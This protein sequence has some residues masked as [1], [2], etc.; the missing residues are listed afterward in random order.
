M[1]EVS[2]ALKLVRQT[3]QTLPPLTVPLPEALGCMLA[4]AIASDVDSPPHDKTIVD[5]YAVRAGDCAKFP[6]TLQVIE[7]VSAGKVPTKVLGTSQAARIMTGA[8]IPSGCDAVVMIEETSST[9]QTSITIS[10]PRVRAGQN[11]VRRASSMAQGEQ[12][13]SPGMTLRSIELGLLAEVGRSTVSVIPRP[14]VAILPTGNELVPIT[15]EP[16]PGFIRNSNGPMLAALVKD[17]GCQA[18]ELDVAR[19]ETA[20]LRQR[21][22]EG[23]EADV[24]LLSGGVSMGAYDLVPGTLA[25]LGVQ[26]VFHKLNLKPGKPLW[27]GVREA[28]SV[29]AG[30]ARSRRT[31]VFGLPGNPVSSLVCFALFVRPA[32]AWLAGRNDGELPRRVVSLAHDFHYR[33]GRASYIPASI[34]IANDNKLLASLVPYS[35][36]GDLRALARSQALL[37]F[38]GGE[39]LFPAGTPVEALMLL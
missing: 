25:D 3:S 36:S 21:C 23:L 5:G 18:I 2:D 16:A 7:E 6:V 17:A 33:G 22:D 19:D 13:L 32:L 20:E 34:T 11:I 15:S 39:Q 10:A 37:N 28:D 9:E 24:L 4:E 1:L 29:D 8:P 31:L 12:V 14:R 35:G 38:S 27:F 26:Q 30:S